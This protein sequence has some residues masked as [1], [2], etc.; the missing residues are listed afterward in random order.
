[1]LS[2]G[3]ILSPSNSTNDERIIAVSGCGPTFPQSLRSRA[4][5]GAIPRGQLVIIFS[6]PTF[7]QSLRSRAV[8]G[9][10][11][12]GQL[13]IIFSGPTFPQ[14]LSFASGL[15]GDPARPADDY[16]SGPTFP[17]SLRSRAPNGRRTAPK[18]ILKFWQHGKWTERRFR[19]VP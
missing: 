12:R 2:G 13:V 7:P 14:S 16:F 6:G 8:W 18:E 4:V 19:I 3:T 10:I 17:Q 11:P 15:G 5:W 9:A 1:M